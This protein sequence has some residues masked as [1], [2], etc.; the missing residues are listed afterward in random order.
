MSPFFTIE[1]QE[2][3]ITFNVYSELVFILSLPSLKAWDLVIHMKFKT[4]GDMMGDGSLSS[5]MA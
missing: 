1:D 3:W 5:I 2:H 4:I